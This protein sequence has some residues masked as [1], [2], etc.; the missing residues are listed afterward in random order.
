MPMCKW[1]MLLAIAFVTSTAVD[2][3]DTQDKTT[4]PLIT[5]KGRHDLKTAP[6]FIQL[7]TEERTS[8]IPGSSWFKSLF[9]TT[10]DFAP[11]TKLN[12]KLVT[13]SKH[14]K[15]HEVLMKIKKMPEYVKQLIEK[16]K[17]SPFGKWIIKKMA[18]KQHT[19]VGYKAIVT[20]S[21][22]KLK[23]FLLTYSSSLLF[24]IGILALA[25]IIRNAV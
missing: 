24:I 2:T 13:I 17:R 7:A 11:V 5:R 1:W 10:S 6:N 23:R 22:S 8:T 25:F 19:N 3:K 12:S 20:S 18:P 9:K 14:S 4:F 21:S 15:V 16:F